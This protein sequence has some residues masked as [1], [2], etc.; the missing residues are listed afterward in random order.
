MK[1]DRERMVLSVESELDAGG[2]EIAGEL[3][4][5][6][7]L[8]CFSGG[9][10]EEAARLSGIPLRLLKRYEEKRVRH[11]YDLTAENE[12]QLRLPPAREFLAA[13]LA[14]CRSEAEQG[15]CILVDHHSN[16][17]VSDLPD[18]VSVF[19]HADRES[20]LRRFA[21][22][23]GMSIEKA[24]RAFDKAERERTLVYKSVAPKWG[25]AAN[26]DLSVNATGATPEQLAAHIVRY[27]ETVTREDLIHPTAALGRSA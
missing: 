9:L 14:A 11:A 2:E 24:A 12:D 6:L 4:R 16:A 10:L 19:V 23:R 13:Q 26:Y 1:I 15:P 22:R 27:L 3:G 7:R 21:I 18:A 20:R 17:A 8:R 5:L 25:K